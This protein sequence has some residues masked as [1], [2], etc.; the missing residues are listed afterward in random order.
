MNDKGEYIMIN[1]FHYL[2]RNIILKTLTE[3][4]NNKKLNVIGLPRYNDNI[5]IVPQINCGPRT[6]KKK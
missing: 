4:Y 5:A 3:L 1:S 6:S 2:P